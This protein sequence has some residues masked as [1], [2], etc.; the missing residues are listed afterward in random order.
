MPFGSSRQ[1]PFLALGS[2]P[3]GHEV[4]CARRSMPLQRDRFALFFHD[5]VPL[6]PR[7]RSSLSLANR[8][9][10]A[11]QSSSLPPA[12]VGSDGRNSPLL[13]ATSCSPSSFQTIAL[14]SFQGV[15]SFSPSTKGPFFLGEDANFRRR[16]S[17]FFFF[18]SHAAR[19]LGVFPRGRGFF[20]FTFPTDTIST[21]FL[22]G[23][24]ANDRFSRP[25]R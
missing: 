16:S 22:D 21:L 13:A 1:R 20:F 2:P 9:S 24:S 12:E 14:L 25:S 8:L 4:T 19:Y 10:S 23:T 11:N 17:R 3:P 7:R 15:L 5:R 6:F 18:L